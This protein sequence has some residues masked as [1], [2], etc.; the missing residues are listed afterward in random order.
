[1]EEEYKLRWRDLI[2]FRGYDNY[3]SRT[4]SSEKRIQGTSILIPYNV[5]FSSVILPLIL[6]SAYEGLESLLK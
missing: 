2:P 5:F 1:M 6:M 4:T 3:I